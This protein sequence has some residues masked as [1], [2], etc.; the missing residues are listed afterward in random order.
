MELGWSWLKAQTTACQM[1]RFSQ[2][3]EGISTAP[4]HRGVPGSVLAAAGDC[5]SSTGCR[6]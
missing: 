5:C 1:N 3:L 4:G 2:V 6:D